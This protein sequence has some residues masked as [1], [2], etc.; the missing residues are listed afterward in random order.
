MNAT[1]FNKTKTDDF[2]LVL[3]DWI[4]ALYESKIRRI[5]FLRFCADNQPKGTLGKGGY[6]SLY[7]HAVFTGAGNSGRDI[8]DLQRHFFVPLENR[9]WMGQILFWHH[10]LDAQCVSLSLD[11]H[12]GDLVSSLSYQNTQKTMVH[13]EPMSA[14]EAAG[15]F[16]RHL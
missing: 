14:Y 7:S 1:Q 10:V 6:L 9:L 4:N 13:D 5:S 12:R 3:A 16:I 15:W 11:I 2:N 8:A